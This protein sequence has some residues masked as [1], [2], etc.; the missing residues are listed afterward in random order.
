V[1]VKLGPM[2]MVYRGTGRFEGISAEERT[3]VIT[4]Q[5]KESR[6]S[7][8]AKATITMSLRPVGEHT[9]AR[10]ATDLAITGKPAQLGRGLIEDVAGRLI[11][12]FADNLAGQIGAEAAPGPRPTTSETD[13]LDVGSLGTA[14]LV[15]RGWPVAVVVVAA[16]C[17]LA[18]ALGRRRTR[19]G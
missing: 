8:T 2:Q 1:K 6:G 16:G 17:A 19:R 7:G 13:V 3:A 4:A 12:T 15:R 9:L 5:A 11:A 10:V 18:L 14:V